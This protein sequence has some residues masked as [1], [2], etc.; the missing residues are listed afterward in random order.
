[1][2]LTLLSGAVYGQVPAAN[3]TSDGNYN[4]GVGQYALGGPAVSN[5][6]LYNSAVGEQ[7]LSANTSGTYNTAVGYWALI[8]A[9][10]N[11]NTAVGAN[12]LKQDIT[13]AANTA[14]GNSALYFNSSGQN[15][16]ATGSQALFKNDDENT[17]ASGNT[18]D[19]AN[20]MNNNTSG[21]NNTAVGYQSLQGYT[22]PDGASGS[23]NTAIGA[24]ALY[25]YSTGSSNTAS[26]Q[27]ALYS[28]TTGGSNTA[29]GSAAL[30]YNA[31]G[32]NNTADGEG[33]MYGATGSNNTA[34]GQNA[35][36]GSV[37]GTGN[38]AFGYEAGLNVTSGSDNIEIGNA[39]TTADNKVIRIGTKDIQKKTYIAGIYSNTAVSG[40]AVVIGSNGELGAVSSSERFKTAIAP[41]GSTTAKL[42]KLRPV[43]F[44]YK[45]DALGTL[46][47]GLIAEEVAKVYPELVIRD[48]KGRVDGVR[49]DELAPMLLNE[50]QRQ[51]KVVAAQAQEIGDLKQQERQFATQ[52]EVQELKRQLQAA[53]AALQAKDRLVAQR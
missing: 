24:A 48:E 14:V 28:N 31:S 39:G 32:S 23:D 52:S 6:G 35:L 18:A 5:G 20:A 50:L 43:T 17:G 10:S 29:T 11:S 27:N 3:G 36:K 45:A 19:G 44:H 7:A 9:N 15:N 8:N 4:T 21:N 22:G 53:L 26:G 40:L 13:G 37:T 30:Y 49:Y 1:M 46:R 12:T 25:S 41:M 38:T 47:Y 2:A 16:T 42:Q 34:V 33:A 51:Q